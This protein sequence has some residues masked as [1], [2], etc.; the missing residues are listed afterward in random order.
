MQIS[1]AAAR[2][3][4]SGRISLDWLYSRLSCPT[5]QDFVLALFRLADRLQLGRFAGLVPSRNTISRMPLAQ[6]PKLLQEVQSYFP[7]YYRRTGLW[8][9]LVAGVVVYLASFLRHQL[10]PS[11]L[12]LGLGGAVYFILGH[13]WAFV[14][15]FI[16]ARLSRIKPGDVAQPVPYY[17]PGMP[18]ASYQPTFLPPSTLVKFGLFLMVVAAASA[19]AELNRSHFAPTWQAL[20]DLLGMAAESGFIL[21]CWE[22]DRAIKADRRTPG[23]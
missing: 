18:A 17:T 2:L 5:G 16:R 15:N 9:G 4:G 21:G 11:W 1:W 8:F 13:A 10:T 3:R 6:Q 19:A 23:P 22:I 14:L 7:P 12:A 20:D